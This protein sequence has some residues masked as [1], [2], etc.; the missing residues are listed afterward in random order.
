MSCASAHHTKPHQTTLHHTQVL[1]EDQATLHSL[2][3]D[4]S[5]SHTEAV[6]SVPVL[7]TQEVQQ[8]VDTT[9]KPYKTMVC[10]VCVVW[11]MCVYCMCVYCMC[12]YC[13]CVCVYSMCVYVCVHGVV[14]CIC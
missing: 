11:R 8:V 5:T 2:V 7:T 10:G 4:T 12:V 14:V 6:A 13:M 3:Q 1:A 9:F